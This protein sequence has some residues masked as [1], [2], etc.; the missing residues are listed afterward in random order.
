MFVL[1]Q[2]GGSAYSIDNAY[3]IRLEEVEKNKKRYEPYLDYAAVII[4]YYNNEG[5]CVI[6]KYKEMEEAKAQFYDLLMA[7][8]EGAVI[9]DFNGCLSEDDKRDKETID[10]E[11]P[12]L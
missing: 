3:A 4:I 5:G 1:E 11:E 6:A 7:I 9:Y 12:E 8:S 2:E 10:E